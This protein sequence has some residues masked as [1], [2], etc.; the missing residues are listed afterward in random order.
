MADIDSL[1]AQL[2]AATKAGRSDDFGANLQDWVSS[3]K[4][5]RPRLDSDL[6]V[7]PPLD[8]R[9]QQM[10]TASRFGAMAGVSPYALPRSLWEV[11][12]GRIPEMDLFKGNEVTQR[13]QK[14][15]P[16]ARRAYEL[17]CGKL[18]PPCDFQV[19]PKHIWLGATPDGLVG[20]AGL[21]EIKC[22]LHKAH[23]KIPPHYMAQIQGQ[24]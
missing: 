2:E 5:S 15:E 4:V 21:L 17:R 9:R 10:Y 11:M 24:L 18:A 20:E 19:H 22:P 7:A 14:L 16:V 1:L 13:G 12:T 8:P 6:V 3:T 23:E